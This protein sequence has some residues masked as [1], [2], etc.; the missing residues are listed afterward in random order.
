MISVEGVLWDHLA[1]IWIGYALQPAIPLYE[2]DLS[3]SFFI[4]LQIVPR[5]DLLGLRAGGLIVLQA[6][7]FGEIL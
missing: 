2:R 7:N 6:V 3:G 4:R 5:D 1:K